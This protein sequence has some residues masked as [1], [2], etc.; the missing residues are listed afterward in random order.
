MTVRRIIL[1][2]LL[3][4]LFSCGMNIWE[5]AASYAA[6]FGDL[7]ETGI[8][9]VYGARGNNDW[10]GTQQKPKKSIQE[11]IALVSR[12]RGTGEVHVAEGLYSPETPVVVVDGISLY[13]GFS[14]ATWERDPALYQTVVAAR[15]D[16]S[17]YIAGG[18]TRDTVIDGFVIQAS[19]EQTA[20]WA[21]Y[22][23]NAS[24]TITGNVIQGGASYDYVSAILI[25][26]GSPLL[27]GNEIYGGS[28]SWSAGVY[29][30][31]AS[32]EI[33]ANTIHAGAA[34]GTACGVCCAGSS[35]PVLR[36]N[37]I[38][39]GSG[40]YTAGI[41]IYDSTEARLES[42]T[43]VAG[44]GSTVSAAVYNGAPGTYLVNNILAADPASA[45]T[46]GIQTALSCAE[47]GVFNNDF[48][49][50][51]YVY[52]Y[53]Q[54]AFTAATVAEMNAL[55]AGNG[56]AFAGNL[57]LDPTFADEENGDLH[58]TAATP[59]QILTGGED[60]SAQFATDIEEMSRTVPWSIGAYERDP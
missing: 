49:H 36:N 4:L 20:H 53:N 19:G 59:I 12:V 55:L 1:A 48:H 27:E 50:T 58:L 34:G 26:Y 37:V 44:K 7:S 21:V 39:G 52:S 57:L 24:P 32:P 47:S 14:A 42:N 3:L 22:C 40:V 60:L 31:D 13:G 11:A 56:T 28:S 17:L 43:I 29:A 45:Q 41:L 10:P 38:L 51:Q 15:F 9:Y 8:A 25:K 2:V 54:G 16:Y 6:G 33:L 18:I 5:Q 23:F 30:I 35:H 46:L